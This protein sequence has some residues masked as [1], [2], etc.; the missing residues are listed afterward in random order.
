MVR[1]RYGS[2]KDD[3]LPFVLTLMPS[4]VARKTGKHIGTIGP[5]AMDAHISEYGYELKMEALAVKATG[6]TTAEA[7]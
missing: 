2:S 6:L 7:D 5:D 4:R 1:L 3:L